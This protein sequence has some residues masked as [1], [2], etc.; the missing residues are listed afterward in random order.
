MQLWKRNIGEFETE[1]A[2]LTT[3]MET[4]YLNIIVEGNGEH[5]VVGKC[6]PI[7]CNQDYIKWLVLNR[8]QLSTRLVLDT[9]FSRKHKEELFQYRQLMM[10]SLQ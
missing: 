4:V 5:A 6:M 10:E 9:W 7:S 1:T 2:F 8:E 3:D